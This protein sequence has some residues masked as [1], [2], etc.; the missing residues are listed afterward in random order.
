MRAAMNAILYLLR[1]GCPWR[2]LPRDGFTPRSTVYNI[3]RKLGR[4]RCQARAPAVGLVSGPLAEARG[5][6]GVVTLPDLP[7]LATERGGST[8]S[9]R[10]TML[11]R[12]PRGSSPEASC[13]RLRFHPFDRATDGENP[14]TRVRAASRRAHR[15]T[16]L[17]AVRRDDRMRRRDFIR[18]IYG[19]A[20][21]WPCAANA[22]Q[23]HKVWRIGVVVVTTPERG[24][25]LTQGIEQGLADLGDVPGRNIVLLHRSAGPRPDKIKDAIVSLLPQIDLLVAQGTVGGVAAKKVGGGMP[26]VF[27]GVG[28]PVE[29]GLVQSLAHPGGNMTGVT[30][31]AAAATYGKRLQLLKEIVPDLKRVA[32]LRAVGDPNVQFSMTSL[33]AAAPELGITLVPVDIKSADDVETAF[34]KIKNSEAQALLTIAGALTFTIDPEIADRALAAHLPLCSAF[35][36][37]VMAGGLVSLGPDLSAM[38]RDARRA[39]R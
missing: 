28:A 24:A 21:L 6:D 8:Q 35:R 20:V 25:Y 18:A 4:S 16:A 29:I 3:F 26:T 17:L 23:S 7:A 33:D 39:N 22:Q 36:E 2:Y 27:V 9:R 13:G 38:T 37:T 31:E 19:A 15:A 14:T 30:F 1:T 5:Y 12:W 34:T 32:V 10:R 11:T